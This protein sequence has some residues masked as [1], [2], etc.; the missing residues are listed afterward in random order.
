[1]LDNSKKDSGD[2]TN[3]ISELLTEQTPLIP[4]RQQSVPFFKA[5]SFD[6][7]Q[8]YD[9]SDESRMVILFNKI[10]AHVSEHLPETPDRGRNSMDFGMELFLNSLRS[11]HASVDSPRGFGSFPF[12]SRVPSLLTLVTVVSS[13]KL[14]PSSRAR[15][16]VSESVAMASVIRER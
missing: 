5:P 7:S 4:A 11:A 3:A 1:V 15:Q 9:K 10:V 8:A 13:T 6:L 2:R 16:L 14:L 12:F